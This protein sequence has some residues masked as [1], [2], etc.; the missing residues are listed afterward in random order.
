MTALPFETIV[1]RLHWRLA[2][3]RFQLAWAQYEA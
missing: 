2:A 1:S 3:L